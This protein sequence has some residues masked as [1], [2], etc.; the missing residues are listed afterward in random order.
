MTFHFQRQLEIGKKGESLVDNYY[1]DQI[2]RLSGRKADF[3]ILGLDSLFELKSDSYP[4]DK[5]PNFFI[6]KFSDIEKKNPGGPYQ[7]LSHDCKYFCYFFVDAE[8]LFWFNTKKL[9]E[10]C[11]ALIKKHSLELKSVKNTRWVT[12][13]Y[14]INREW[15]R[16]L[17]KEINMK[18]DKPSL[19]WLKDL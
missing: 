1:K 13:G 6:E 12:G 14:L 2:E 16:D 4:M 8:K 15:V 10:R 11:D 19:T 17:Y 9:V 7:A 5:T 18:E 3:K